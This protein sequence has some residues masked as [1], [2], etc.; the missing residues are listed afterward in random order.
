MRSTWLDKE[1]GPSSGESV[2]VVTLAFVLLQNYK[3]NESWKCKGGEKKEKLKKE[4]E[5]LTWYSYAVNA[6]RVTSV[7]L[8]RWYHYV[9]CS[10]FHGELTW[11]HVV[12]PG[13]NI[14][15]SCSMDTS[16]SVISK[17]IL[18]NQII[19]SMKTRVETDFFAE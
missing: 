9:P 1:E 18:K 5:S 14:N 16:S 8:L 3:A 7:K 17:C 6:K 4:P 13:P 2:L 19:S 15:C 10:P 12:R 11:D